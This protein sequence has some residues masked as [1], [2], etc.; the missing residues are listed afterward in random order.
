MFV[1]WRKR[2]ITSDRRAELFADCWGGHKYTGA[3]SFDAPAWTPLYCDHKGAGRIS[4]IPCLMHCERREGKPRQ[5]LVRRLHAIRSCCLADPFMLAAW[6]H[7]FDVHDR[8]AA[9][10]A[11]GALRRFWARDRAAVLAKLREVVPRPGKAGKAGVAAFT[12]HRLRKE[13]ERAEAL[14]ASQEA[15]RRERERQERERL[16]QAEAAAE[17]TA[18]MQEELRRAWEELVGPGRPP[19]THWSDV[20]GVPRSATLDQ[21]K[22][23]WRELALL[24]HPDRGGD[25]AVFIKVQAAYERA[26]RELR[27]AG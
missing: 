5:K 19:G 18:R 20:L 6:W 21:V 10:D 9:E 27:P 14:R 16:R 15:L 1:V 23:R 22:T 4:H 2:V 8:Y 25:A 3:D 11:D 13:A 12:A 24:H 7:A 26:E 17:R